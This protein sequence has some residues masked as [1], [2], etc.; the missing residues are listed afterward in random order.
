MTDENIVQDQRLESIADAAEANINLMS[1]IYNDRAVSPLEKMKGFTQGVGNMTRL[2][3]IELSR[4]KLAKATGIQPPAKSLHA[5]VFM[6]D[7]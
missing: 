7:E 6:P 5:L 3:N 2:N 4:I 1:E